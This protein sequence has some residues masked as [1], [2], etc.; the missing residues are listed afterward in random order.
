MTIRDV[1]VVRL[2]ELVFLCVCVCLHMCVF[3][4][5]S[6]FLHCSPHKIFTWPSIMDCDLIEAECSHLGLSVNSAASTRFHLFIYLVIYIKLR[7]F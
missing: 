7:S 6:H 2:S 4:S 1:F 5:T 3:L